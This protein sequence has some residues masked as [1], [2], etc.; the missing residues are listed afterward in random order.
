MQ[1]LQPNLS[2][3]LRAMT[4]CSQQQ[5]RCKKDVL[6]RVMQRFSIKLFFSHKKTKKALSQANQDYVRASLKHVRQVTG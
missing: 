4:V 2:P 3:V 5:Q 6:S 1:N